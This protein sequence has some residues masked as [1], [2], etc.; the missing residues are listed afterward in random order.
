MTTLGLRMPD[1]LKDRLDSA[2]TLTRRTKSQIALMAIEYYLEELE[3]WVEAKQR[4]NSDEETVS[5]ADVKKEL[6][7]D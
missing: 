6:G 3:F 7:L 1:A 5:H 4:H 2:A